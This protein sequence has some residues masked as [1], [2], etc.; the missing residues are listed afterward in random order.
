MLAGEAGQ[1]DSPDPR[2]K[3]IVWRSKS[4]STVNAYLVPAFRQMPRQLVRE[5]FEPAV[6]GGNTTGTEDGDFHVRHE[7]QTTQLCN[8]VNP[9]APFTAP[10]IAHERPMQ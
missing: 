2:I 9:L 4:L 3:N 8:A 6:A 7:G 10:E 1:D 5:R